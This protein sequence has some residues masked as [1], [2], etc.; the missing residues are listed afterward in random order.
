MFQKIRNSF[1]AL[2]DVAFPGQTAVI[3]GKYHANSQFK[4]GVHQFSFE[5]LSSKQIFMTVDDELTL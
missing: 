1:G 5:I 4:S 2:P 3:Q